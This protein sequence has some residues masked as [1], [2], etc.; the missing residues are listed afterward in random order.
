MGKSVLHVMESFSRQAGSPAC[1]WYDLLTELH[2]C[3]VTSSLVT[4]RDGEIDP[5][6]APPHL[7]VTAIEADS[8]SGGLHLRGLMNTLIREV[9]LVHLHGSANRL[10]RAAASAASR[11]GRPYV[12]SPHMSLAPNPFERMA[13]RRKLA[14]WLYGNGI[15]RGAACLHAGSP[16]E[17]ELIRQRGFRVRVE[18]IPP[19]ID[20]QP[21]QQSCATEALLRAVPPLADHRCLLFLGRIHPIEGL[22]PLLRACQ[23]LV[24]QLGDWHLV[25]AG[26]AP[27]S[28]RG[29]IEA[30]IRRRGESEGVT[31]LAAPDAPRQNQL[32]AQAE[33]LVQPCLCPQVPTAVLQAMAGGV[34]V[35][36]SD[37]YGLP[38]IQ[39]R[40]AGLV[41][42]PNQRAVSQALEQMLTAAQERRREMGRNGRN[43]VG[44]EFNCQVHAPRFAELY[45]SLG[46]APS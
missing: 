38:Q 25:L 14:A 39:E 31:V 9:D 11:A 21:Y 1:L 13:L 32:L 29:Q 17:A 43:L 2:T 40:Q 23:G 35:I 27:G 16:T 46:S 45:E 34:P 37:Q 44:Q 7:K 30:A 26:P 5:S 42:A 18:V 8:T 28:W 15:I 10:N 20:P 6:S 19:C 24:D 41:T 33:L 3:G 22:R 12:V 36:A 4:V